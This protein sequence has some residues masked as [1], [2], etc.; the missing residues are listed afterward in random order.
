[1]NERDTLVKA[2]GEADAFA[3]LRLLDGCALCTLV[4]AADEVG[5][6][7]PEWARAG[8][9]L[10]HWIEARGITADARRK[11]GYLHCAAEGLKT[12]P[13][14]MRPTLAVAVTDFLA[15]HGFAADA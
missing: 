12:M 14:A 6:D 15:A 3:V 1:M 9:V 10:Q 2:V 7:W 11:I 8:A 4:D 5:Q 13:A